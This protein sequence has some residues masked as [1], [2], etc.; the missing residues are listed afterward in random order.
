MLF[1]SGNLHP[2]ALQ[3]FIGEYRHTTL[4][5]AQRAAELLADVVRA[6][7]DEQRATTGRSFLGIMGP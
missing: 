2:N 4:Q 7:I 5:Q 6:V 3:V 1:R